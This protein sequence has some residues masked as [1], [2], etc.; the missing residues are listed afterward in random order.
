MFLCHQSLS[1]NEQKQSFVMG[2]SYVVM[3]IDAVQYDINVK[4]F[5]QS[6]VGVTIVGWVDEKSI[7]NITFA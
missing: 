7:F 5:Y 2:C 4:S 1:Q 3:D 6:C